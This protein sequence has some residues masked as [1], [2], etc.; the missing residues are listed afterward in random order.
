MSAIARFFV[1]NGIEVWG[2]DKTATPL[3]DVLADEGVKGIYFED[4]EEVIPNEIINGNAEHTVIVYTPA[5]PESNQIFRRLKASKIPIFKRAEMLGLI[6]QNT[7]NLSVAGTHGKTTTSCMLT[8]L[9]HEAK[10]PF[11]AFLGGIATNYNSN[12][13]STSTTDGGI[14]ITEADEYDRSF[15]QLR[16]SIAG[17]T[18]MDADHLDIYGRAD[19]VKSGFVE[20]ANCVVNDG[21]LFYQYSQKESLQALQRQ[22]K[23]YGID[24]GEIQANNVR[25]ANGSFFFD[26]RGD[27]EMTGLELGLP[28]IHN[29]ENAVLAISMALEVGV[30]ENSIREALRNFKG[31]KRRF[32]FIRKSDNKV[33]ID[34]YAHHPTEIRSTLQSIKMLYPNKHLT[35]VFQPHLYS[36]TRDFMNDFAIELSQ[37]DELI[38]LPIYPAREE[39]IEGINS[40]AL[41]NQIKCDGS[42]VEKRDLVDYLKSK[43]IEVLVTLGAGDIDQLIEPLKC[44][45]EW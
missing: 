16:P 5:I 28:G 36:R 11:D 25:I 38:L 33:F 18:S 19:D 17:I 12:Y 3:T 42:L 7:K 21:L 40:N 26:Y 45:L 14:S 31:V 23:S 20:F 43:N 30:N 41:L 32:E 9:L 35:V 4:R 29:V 10:I 2:Y 39:P 1:Q 8:H 27:I 22:S 15:L 13:I 44:E 6:T 37:V 34:D 24:H